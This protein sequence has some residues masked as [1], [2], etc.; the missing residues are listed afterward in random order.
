MSAAPR[1]CKDCKWIVPSSRPMCMH[2]SSVT[3]AELDVVTGKTRPS[4]PMSCE[5]ARLFLVY[6]N[7]CGY[8]GKHWEPA[9]NS[10]VGFT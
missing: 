3:P 7:H 10:T 1:L 8:E 4:Q 9:D 2:P 5:Q 6:G